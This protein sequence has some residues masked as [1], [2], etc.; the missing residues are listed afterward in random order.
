[1]RGDRPGTGT[2]EID[3]TGRNRAGTVDTDNAIT[4]KLIGTG[5]ERTV[6][7]DNKTQGHTGTKRAKDDDRTCHGSLRKISFGSRFVTNFLKY[8]IWIRI[9]ECA[10]D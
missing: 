5:T 9:T 4:A 10:G 2:V 6:G 7:M 3:N 1:M 8:W